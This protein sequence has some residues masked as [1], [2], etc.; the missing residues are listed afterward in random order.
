M[1][2]EHADLGISFLCIRIKKRM[3]IS[4]DSDMVRYCDNV[5]RFWCINR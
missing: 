2:C 3:K 4:S 1:E 5:F